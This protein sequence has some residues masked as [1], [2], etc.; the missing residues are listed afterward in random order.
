[1]RPYLKK[2]FTKIGLVEWFKVKALSSS[3]STTHKKM[4]IFKSLSFRINYNK[5]IKKGTTVN[6]ISQKFLVSFYVYKTEQTL[7]DLN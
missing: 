7:C 3:S 4:V 1:M 2:H 6:Q 5:T